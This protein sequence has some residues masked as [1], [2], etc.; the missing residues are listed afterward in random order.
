VLQLKNIIDTVSP[1]DSGKLISWDGQ[2]IQ[3]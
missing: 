1:S 2:E 3:P